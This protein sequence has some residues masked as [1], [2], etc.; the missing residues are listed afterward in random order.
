MQNRIKNHMWNGPLGSEYETL[1]LHFQEA[2]TPSSSSDHKKLEKALAEITDRAQKA[3]TELAI[4]EAENGDMVKQLEE[5]KGLY[6]ILEKK[7]HQAKNTIKEHEAKW[8]SLV[9]VGEGLD[10]VRAILVGDIWSS[11]R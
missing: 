6:L 1:T 2:S 4:A 9:A 3:E 10:Q 8:V 5:S 11:I 7:Y